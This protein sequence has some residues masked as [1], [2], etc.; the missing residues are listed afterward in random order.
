MISM[1]KSLDGIRRVLPLLALES[2]FLLPASVRAAEAG[3][4]NLFDGKTLDGW[5]QH[6]GKAL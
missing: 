5:E 6:S 3:W 1:K 2:S 4:V